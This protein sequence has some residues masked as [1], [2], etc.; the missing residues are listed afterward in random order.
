MKLTIYRTVTTF[1]PNEVNKFSK[2][3]K[4]VTFL[5]FTI[6]LDLEK[7]ID[8]LKILLSQVNFSFKALYLIMP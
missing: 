5:Y 3:N 6:T 7:T 2:V 1:Q 8:S 4:R